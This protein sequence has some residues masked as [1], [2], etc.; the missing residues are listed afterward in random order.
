M[1]IVLG[2]LTLLV[3]Y[4]VDVEGRDKVKPS[5]AKSLLI[6]DN[7]LLQVDRADLSGNHVVSTVDQTNI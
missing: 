1:M 5:S 4:F 6:R 2:G 7:F 3:D